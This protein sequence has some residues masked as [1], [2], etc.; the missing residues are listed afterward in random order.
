[1]EPVAAF[2]SCLRQYATFSGRAPRSEFWFFVLLKFISFYALW[3]VTGMVSMMIQLS[4][5]FP[6]PSVHPPPPDPATLY[7][8]IPNLIWALILLLPSIAV[9]VRRL[10]DIDRSGWWWWLNGVP[11][12]GPLWLLYWDCISGTRGDNHFGADPLRAM[13]DA[14]QGA[15]MEP[16]D[17]ITS[18]LSQYATIRGRAS[19]AEFWFFKL[20]NTVIIWVLTLVMG[21]AVMIVLLRAGAFKPGAHP[22]PTAILFIMSAAGLWMLAM[23]LP[24]AAVAVRRLHDINRSG[25]WYWLYLIP[26]AGLVLMLVWNCERGT[27]G[28]NRY[29][30]DPLMPGPW[31]GRR[32]L[33]A[34]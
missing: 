3:F 6:L 32:T 25:W 34:R 23:L 13:G 12:A 22:N 28:P 33:S 8:Q 2:K 30:R 29:G 21:I 24:S 19:R 16:L 1:M 4:R 17:A 18:C 26:L 7:A 31:D 27:A 14:G 5:G 10:H 15:M 20:F 11:I 9:E